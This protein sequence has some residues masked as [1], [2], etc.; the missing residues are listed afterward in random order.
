M[1]QIKENEQ[2]HSCATDDIENLYKE[3]IEDIKSIMNQNNL[4]QSNGA[5]VKICS[6]D[7]E[8]LENFIDIIY[9]LTNEDVSNYKIATDLI[10]K[11][12]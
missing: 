10:A 9:N 2:A 5:V 3:G 8:M 4:N 11:Y 1:A 7:I 12:S 6:K